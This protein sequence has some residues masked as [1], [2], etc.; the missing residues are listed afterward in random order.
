MTSLLTNNAAMTALTTLKNITTQLDVTSNR[1]S[2]GLRVSSAADNAAYWSIATT[3]RAD[4]G[5]L[6]AIKDVLG[7]GSSSIDTAYNG[8]NA[9]IENVKNLRNQLTSALS[10]NVDR[11]KVQFEI[12]AIQS[13]MKA[14]A[15]SSVMSG[16]N[17]LSVDSSS[18][19]FAATQKITAGF[20]RD[21]A[22]G[23][24]FSEVSINVGN[25]GGLK[26]YDAGASAGTS[27]KVTAAASFGPTTD[28]STAIAF[29]VN[30]GGGAVTVTL[31]AAKFPAAS[32]FD[33][34]KVTSD[35]IVAEI[36]NQLA[37]DPK[38]NGAVTAS[39]DEDGRLQFETT[40]LGASASV[41]V[42][43]TAAGLGF[44]T[45]AQTGTGVAGTAASKGIL[46]SVD[47]IT[48][49]S[50]SNI[51]ISTA[52]DAQVKAY[53]TQVDKALAAMTNTATSL[54][55]SKK[56]VDGQKAFID[57][58]MKANDRTIGT[59]VDADIEEESTKLKALQTQQQ[60]GVQALSIA[61][62]ASQNVLSLFR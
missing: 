33:P 13:T 10:S 27:G 7:I 38:T 60:L 62:S 25:A 31:N 40:K 2:T 61:N 5:S 22:G 12:S 19:K 37:A 9:I 15:D 18:A 3:V 47:A 56:Q 59:L 1:V 51:D 16:Q 29:S 8:I 53:I 28:V 24:K 34:T 43:F 36:N 45:T 41:V 52:T 6:G 46:D 35:Q 55:S 30:A 14:T 48:G 50:V 21:I 54:G 42:T 26:L 4:N 32:G 58:L 44:G 57:T 39:L 49:K 17:W 11:A 23:I 20:S